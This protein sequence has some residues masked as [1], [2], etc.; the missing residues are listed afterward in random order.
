[1]RVFSLE[2]SYSEI[3]WG[4]GEAISAAWIAVAVNRRQESAQ[5]NVRIFV[6]VNCFLFKD[7]HQHQIRMYRGT[8]RFVRY[9]RA[10]HH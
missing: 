7:M 6:E 5:N 2:A 9:N 10:C 1:M 3:C 4:D 8:R